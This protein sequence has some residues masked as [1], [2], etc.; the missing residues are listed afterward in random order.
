MKTMGSRLVLSAAI[1]LGGFAACNETVGECWY[2]GEGTENAG[3]GPGGGVMKMLRIVLLP[4]AMK[5]R[6]MRPSWVRCDVASPPGVSIAVA[7]V[8]R[9]GST[10]LRVTRTP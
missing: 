8:R 5:K 4:T 9:A 6:M 2:Y 10:A 1:T 7:N 3:A